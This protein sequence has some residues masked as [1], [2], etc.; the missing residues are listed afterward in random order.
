[1]IQILGSATAGH[2]VGL[3]HPTSQGSSPGGP[4]IFHKIQ[5]LMSFRPRDCYVVEAK[6]S[7]D[8]GVGYWGYVDQKLRG[9][10]KSG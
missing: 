4:T 5:G 7:G 8:L 10:S 6:G 1:M 9:A 2:L 3:P